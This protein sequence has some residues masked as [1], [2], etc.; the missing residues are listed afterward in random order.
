MSDDGDDSDDGDKKMELDL[1]DCWFYGTLM[2]RAARLGWDVS[3]LCLFAV[4]LEL[5]LTLFLLDSVERP[6]PALPISLTLEVAILTAAVAWVRPFLESIR[7]TGIVFS[8]GEPDRLADL[9][10]C[11][12]GFFG[13]PECLP[14]SYRP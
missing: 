2:T 13:T 6:M 5:A 1:G 7:A 10:P 12:Y 9:L 4:A 14:A 3:I 8:N 11:H